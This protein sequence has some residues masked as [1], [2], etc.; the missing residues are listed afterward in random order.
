MLAASVTSTAAGA[1]DAT[2][3]LPAPDEPAHCCITPAATAAAATT[4][5]DRTQPDR[6]RPNRTARIH[7]PVTS[8]RP[9]AQNQH[10]HDAADAH[11]PSPPTRPQ[12][13]RT[14][15]NNQPANYGDRPNG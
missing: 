1:A 9:P 10:Q 11:P 6:T 15:R 3:V 14:T 13:H 4:A 2:P 8:P 12:T 7:A 5:T